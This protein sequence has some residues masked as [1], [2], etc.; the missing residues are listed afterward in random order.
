MADGIPL[1]HHE[2]RVKPR[3]QEKKC[4]ICH[5]RLGNEVVFLSACGHHVYMDCGHIQFSDAKKCPRNGCE[6]F[7]M[8]PP[9]RPSYVKVANTDTEHAVVCHICEPFPNAIPETG[10]F[11]EMSCSGRHVFHIDCIRFVLNS[12]RN[13]HAELFDNLN[14]VTGNWE[15]IPCPTCR[16]PI[17]AMA[18]FRL[19]S[20]RQD[21]Y[22]TTPVP[23]HNQTRSGNSPPISNRESPKLIEDTAT[24]II[25]PVQQP[26][27]VQEPMPVQEPVHEQS[28]ELVSV[29][30]NRAL[31]IKA[32]YDS[33]G[34]M[35]M[36]LK[37]RAA[38]HRGDSTSIMF[39]QLALAQPQTE[40]I[41]FL[42][43]TYRPDQTQSFNYTVVAHPHDRMLAVGKVWLSMLWTYDVD[44]LMLRLLFTATT[45]NTKIEWTLRVCD[46]VSRNGVELDH[47]LI[48]LFFV[49][50]E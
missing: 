23:Q 28:Q 24:S 16:T 46:M 11:M 12:F 15:N 10:D 1:Q 18:L 43:L 42:R 19:L 9:Y 34:G 36:T 33:M 4:A 17:S 40:G 6:S 21:G 50:C 31:R 41:Q 39:T 48:F 35:H 25:A 8:S 47:R 26:L 3:S 27:P 29:A 38:S 2:S 49:M 20:V 45:N 30:Q 37:T 44:P 7:I 22:S 32:L 5:V 13:G 14:T